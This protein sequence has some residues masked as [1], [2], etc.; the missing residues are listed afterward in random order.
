MS[1]DDGWPNSS[2]RPAEGG[3]WVNILRGVD[4]RE[5]VN[6]LGGRLMAVPGCGDAAVEDA[7][8]VVDV[9]VCAVAAD[10]AV[11]AVVSLSGAVAPC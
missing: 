11:C 3:V 2:R 1:T 6:G 10:A 9:V 5:L 7:P 8:P 4:G